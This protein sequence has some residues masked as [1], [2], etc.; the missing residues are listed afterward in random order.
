LYLYLAYAG[1]GEIIYDLADR[2]HY[3]TML[4]VEV[5]FDDCANLTALIREHRNNITMDI[6]V[7]GGYHFPC[8][9]DSFLRASFKN[10]QFFF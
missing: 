6:P 7:G 4:I 8:L 5:G 1:G 2:S 10:S 3:G 9:F